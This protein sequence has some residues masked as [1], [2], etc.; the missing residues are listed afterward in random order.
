[1]T[2]EQLRKSAAEYLQFHRHAVHLLWR[3][4]SDIL[5][6]LCVSV[7]FL[8]S[9]SLQKKQQHRSRVTGPGRGASIVNLPFQRDRKARARK[10]EE[11]NGFYCNYRA[12]C[13]A[14][15]KIDL[16]EEI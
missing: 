3:K 7:C 6:N 15:E 4:D 12:R 13:I 2:K 8:S 16:S 5:W 14:L 10:G 11:D 1:M 9:S